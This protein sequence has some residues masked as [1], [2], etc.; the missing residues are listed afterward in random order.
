MDTG[1]SA[2]VGEGKQTGT[3]KAALQLKDPS[4]DRPDTK[5]CTLTSDIGSPALEDAENPQFHQA[6]S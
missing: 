6:D 5:M 2:C 1:A 3:P 4:S